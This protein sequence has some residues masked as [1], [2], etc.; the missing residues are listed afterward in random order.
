M[1]SDTATDP[2][3]L[4]SLMHIASPRPQAGGRPNLCGAPQTTWNAYSGLDEAYRA[5]VEGWTFPARPVCRDCLAT[6]M[7]SM[8][9]SP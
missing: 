8:G 6:A 5:N 2:G 9:V 1:E 4:P 3:V 7:I